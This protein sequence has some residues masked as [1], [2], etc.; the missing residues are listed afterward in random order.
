MTEAWAWGREA[1]GLVDRSASP[2]DDPARRPS[3]ADKR[4]AWRRELL[5]AEIRAA[6]GPG[7][8]EAEF[9]AVAERLLSLAA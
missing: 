6:L 8:T 3:H 5:G 2:W 1:E 4:R 9:Q 7:V